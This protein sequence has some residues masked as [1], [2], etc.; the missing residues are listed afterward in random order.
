MNGA[1]S[2]AFE[3]PHRDAFYLRLSIGPALVY[4]TGDGPAGAT[5]INGGGVGLA[6]A[7]GG[8]PVKGF[9]LAATFRIFASGGTWNGYADY[10]ATSGRSGP[11]VNSVPAVS[12]AAGTAVVQLGLLA[13][14]YPMAESG[15]HGGGSI[16]LSGFGIGPNN[17]SSNQTLAGTS[18]GGSL[19]GGYD[20]WL[21]GRWSLGAM[22]V[23]G[24][25][26][27]SSLQDSNRNDSGYS[28]MPFFFSVEGTAVFF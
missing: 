10:S 4:A 21:G 27:R 28:M 23:V 2:D 11:T 5:S 12:V 25:M 16:A 13:D 18:T 9:A 20:W 1:P 22:A 8:A 6:A 14:W 17:G 24:T 15:W 3:S 7:I 26:G 19:F